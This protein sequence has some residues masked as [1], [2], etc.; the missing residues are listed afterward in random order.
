[1]RIPTAACPGSPW[2]SASTGDASEWGHGR[3]TGS[4]DS[5]L[6]FHVDGGQVLAPKSISAM[7]RLPGRSEH[8]RVKLVFRHCGTFFKSACG[9]RTAMRC[10]LFARYWFNFW[11][12]SGKRGGPSRLLSGVCGIISRDGTLRASRRSAWSLRSGT[13]AAFSPLKLCDALGAGSGAES[14]VLHGKARFRGDCGR[15]NSR[16]RPV[17]RC[18]SA[19]CWLAHWNHRRG[20]DW[21]GPRCPTQ[22]I[23]RAPTHR[24]KHRT[25]LSYRRR[26]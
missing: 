22:R 23:H 3:G 5:T 9:G 13:R 1:M 10:S 11:L 17:D 7:S 25:Q 20:S 6:C 16:G 24:P 21:D 18:R 14:A 26:A 19:S 15:A 2:T 12:G 4:I 8:R